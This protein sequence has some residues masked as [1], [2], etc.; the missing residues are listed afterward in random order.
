MEML[1]GGK[2]DTDK[3]NF[4]IK[5]KKHQNLKGIIISRE[6]YLADNKL[7]REFIV[8]WHQIADI[9]RFTVGAKC[10]MLPLNTHNAH[11]HTILFIIILFFKFKNSQAI[12]A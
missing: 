11:T 12:I 3:D 4:Y 9:N 6:S 2:L 5:E 8:Q 10:L 1:Q 7:I